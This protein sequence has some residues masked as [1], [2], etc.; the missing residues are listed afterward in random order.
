[1]SKDEILHRTMQ[2]STKDEKGFFDQISD[3]GKNAARR[4]HKK[5]QILKF[6]P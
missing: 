2:G 3:F 1:M 6:Y 5:K 4:K